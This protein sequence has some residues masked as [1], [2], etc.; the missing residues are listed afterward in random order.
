MFPV[1]VGGTFI[2]PRRETGF[3]LRLVLWG[4]LSRSR[5]TVRVFN[6]SKTLQ[7]GGCSPTQGL[8]SGH[9]HCILLILVF[10]SF[11]TPV[12]QKKVP[13]FSHGL[14]IQSLQTPRRRWNAVMFRLFVSGSK[15]H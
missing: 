12:W 2:S 1:C 5:C 8:I 10:G 13:L 7:R 11:N 6:C 15:R 4:K 9:T 14:M 3:S